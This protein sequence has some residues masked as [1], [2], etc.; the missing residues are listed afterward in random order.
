MKNRSKKGSKLKLLQ[1]VNSKKSLT[2]V[3]SK[4]RAKTTS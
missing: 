3:L 4:S 2:N 1:K